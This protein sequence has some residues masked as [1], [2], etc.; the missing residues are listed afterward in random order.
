MIFVVST[1]SQNRQVK[2]AAVG[3]ALINCATLLDYLLAWRCKF[4][5]FMRLQRMSFMLWWVQLPK[6][7][8]RAQCKLGPEHN[9]NA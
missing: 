5:T 2:S 1:P 9:S 3:F 7:R 8:V 4:R 6:H